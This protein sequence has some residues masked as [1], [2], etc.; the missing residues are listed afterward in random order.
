MGATLTYR[1]LAVVLN[2]AERVT[3]CSG[4]QL[5]HR[6]AEEKPV[7]KRHGKQ[8]NLSFNAHELKQ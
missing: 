5:H 6:L 1:L 3:Q 7:G 2:W 4:D 8:M